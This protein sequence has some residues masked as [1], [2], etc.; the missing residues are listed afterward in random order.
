MPG[1][2]LSEVELWLNERVDRIACIERDRQAQ[3]VKR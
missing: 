1:G 3:P 2:E